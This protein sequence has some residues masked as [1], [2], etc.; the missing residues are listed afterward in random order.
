MGKSFEFKECE[1]FLKRVLKDK[2][3]Y[4]KGAVIA[5][6]I[7]GGIGFFA[8]PAQ[9]IIYVETNLDTG[10]TG[11]ASYYNGN[12]SINLDRNSVVL[13][14][15]KNGNV[16][17]D[18][19]RT[20]KNSVIIGAGS[21][22]HGIVEGA[23]EEKFT[24]VG[25]NAHVAGGQGTAIGSN[26]FAVKQATAV[27]NDVYAAGDSSIAIGNDDISTKY[28]DSLSRETLKGIF[29][30]GESGDP[31]VAKLFREGKWYSSE[32]D[33]KGPFKL[34][35]WSDFNRSYLSDGTEMYSPTYAGGT[36]AIAIGS[37]SIAFKDG[38]TAIGTLSYAFGEGSTAMGL[39][40][41]TA[42]DAAGAVAI[43][44][45][46]RSF[47]AQS[48]A[49]GNRNE[50]TSIGA[51][52]YGY[53]AKAVGTGSLAFG[54]KTY[55]N[56]EITNNIG[57]TGGNVATN[58][59]RASVRGQLEGFS[60][61]Q[62]TALGIY[63]NK[64][65]EYYTKIR[66]QDTAANIASAKAAMNTARAA[67]ESFNYS[68]VDQLSLVKGGFV[69]QQ[70]NKTVEKAIKAMVTSVEN[71]TATP[72]TI[73]K[74][75]DVFLTTTDANGNTQ[76]VQKSKQSGDNAIAI[77]YYSAATGTASIAQGSGSVVDSDSGIG[78]GSLTYV[79]KT[80]ANSIALGV[81]AQVR[82]ENSISI[83]TQSSVYGAGAIGMG[84]GV[85]IMGD[86]S[87]GMGYGTMVKSRGSVSIGN[88]S[89][90]EL[91]SQSST[92]VGANT[93]IGVNAGNS[94]ALGN[95]ARINDE[96]LNS[97]A[98]GFNSRVGTKALNSIAIGTNATISDNATSAVALGE[99]SNVT[100][101]YST[102]LGRLATADKAN[103]VAL[104][105]RSTTFYYGDANTRQAG[106]STTVSGNYKHG[107][108]IEPYLP[109]SAGKGIKEKL[110]HLNTAA[111]GYISVGGWDASVDE[112]GKALNNNA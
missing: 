43:G 53:S 112:N 12:G 89:K 70:K 48:L 4:S 61:D 6:L 86:N 88:G 101:N 103:S 99:K 63:Q 64:V 77:G 26:T 58:P 98:L 44:E 65:E 84:S 69:G 85:R 41:F 72:L 76:K 37:R 32:N 106:T 50:S 93:L 96:A 31:A 10:A 42:A 60:E 35:S 47:A 81:G 18:L 108:D 39:R 110:A 66:N 25:N 17:G 21:Y 11:A 97:M 14:P 75:K 59:L 45:Q 38:S 33:A 78:I 34:T 71:N 68:N 46:S 2:G 1:R 79:G 19:N 73:E 62:L 20:A 40:A 16:Y 67:V 82:K 7:T 22:A 49:V 83:G 27:G 57:A 94:V 5:F 9:A 95:F 92:G 104:G 105:Y 109:D 13:A 52:S 30:N 28:K 55:A 100:A 90:I 74:D 51:M 3:M 36:G 102:A 29:G 111:A 107:L 23:R 80:A 87:L 54:F 56:A 8:P 15:I 24:A 91:G